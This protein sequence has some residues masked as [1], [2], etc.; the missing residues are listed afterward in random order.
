MPR[1]SPSPNQAAAIAYRRTREE[2]EICLI[3][4]KDSSYWGIPKGWIEDGDTEQETVLNEAWE[5]AGVEGKL[6]GESVGLYAYEKRGGE[7]LVAVYLMEV[8]AAHDDWDERGFRIRRWVSVDE[9][10]SLLAD[11][12]ARDVFERALRLL[13]R[14]AEPDS[15]STNPDGRTRR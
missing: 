6:I 2:L 1:A 5:E 11:H 7:Y 10:S 13:S 4:R 8:H 14:L 3:R 9:A 12:P 15:R